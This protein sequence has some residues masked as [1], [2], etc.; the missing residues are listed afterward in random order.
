MAAFN[1]CQDL[2][3]DG[4]WSI[5]LPN[6][7]YQRKCA[8]VHSMYHAMGEECP[9][10]VF[11]DPCCP[12]FVEKLIT[13]A[14]SRRDES[15]EETNTTL[16][17]ITFL[18]QLTT[19]TT[20]KVRIRSE[21][22]NLL[23]AGR[24]STAALMSNVFFELSRRPEIQDRLRQEVATHVGNELPTFEGIKS[25]KYLRAILNESL[26]IHPIVPENARQAVCDTV[27]PLGGGEDGKSPALVKKGQM[28]SWSSYAMHRREDLYGKDA[29][30]FNPERWLD[31]VDGDGRKGLRVGWEYLPF[32]GGPRI[33]IGRKSFDQVF[34]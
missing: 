32:N 21:L 19:E 12:E 3:N 11:V 29:A 7:R 22:L 5:F 31:D 8:I 27:L 15:T 30:E 1:Y 34:L 9:K 28:V 14:V 33:C 20:D 24:D 13:Q 6:R 4:I 17:R 16:K 25:M 10:M 23:L 26:R 2:G 18:D